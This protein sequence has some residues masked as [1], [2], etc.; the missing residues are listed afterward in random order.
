[1]GSVDALGRSNATANIRMARCQRRYHRQLFFWLVST[2]CHHNVRV[3]FCALW[4]NIDAFMKT[5]RH[6][7]FITWFQYT[8][9]TLVLSHCIAK[10]K[11]NLA[12][13]QVRPIFMP[14]GR[15]RPAPLQTFISSMPVG[16][17]YKHVRDIKVGRGDKSHRSTDTLKRNRCK[18]CSYR[19][20]KKGGGS[21]IRDGLSPGHGGPRS[22]RADTVVKAVPQVSYGCSK[23]KVTL[24][25]E[26]FPQSA[27]M[28]DHVL[29][30]PVTRA[31]II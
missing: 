27:N 6:V 18:A 13:G 15:G 3:I 21:G 17:E 19:A 14:A 30:Q 26:C 20:S 24:C 4:P 29:C 8:L 16:H 1:M 31:E 28:W 25:G 23:C 7:G 11:E 12:E 5:H 22:M 9:G 10:A 2:V